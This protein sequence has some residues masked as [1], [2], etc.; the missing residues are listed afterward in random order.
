MSINFAAFSNQDIIAALQTQVVTGD[1][2]TDQDTLYKYSDDQ[3]SVVDQVIL[4]LAVIEAATIA[5]VQAVLAVARQYHLAVITKAT[6]TSVVSGSRGRSGAVILSL[7][8]M[9]HILEVNPD[10]SVA[11]VEPGV[12]NNDLDK[13]A[14]EVGFFA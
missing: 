13:A 6:G 4:P 10:D 5:D 11:V 1:V 14:R 7:D 9:N 3:Y 2:L 8:R 12:I